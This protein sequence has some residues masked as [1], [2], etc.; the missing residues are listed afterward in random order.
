MI[1]F[2]LDTMGPL[3]I[4]AAFRALTASMVIV[5]FL[6]IIFDDGADEE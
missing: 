3:D 2:L 1:D 6:S 4:G 5:L